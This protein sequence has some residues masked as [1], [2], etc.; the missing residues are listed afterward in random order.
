MILKYFLNS[1]IPRWMVLLIDICIS[2][3]SIVVAYLLRFN[4]RIPENYFNK[5]NFDSLYFVI[6]IVL[7]VRLISFLISKSYTGIIRYAGTKDAGRIF[8]VLLSGS[9]I[10]GLINLVFYSYYG[11]FL[12]PLSVIGIDFLAAMFMMTSLRL[13][14]K[15]AYLVYRLRKRDRQNAII[16]GINEMAISTNKTIGKSIELNLRIIGFIDPFHKLA[17]K[18]IDGIPAFRESDLEKVIAK[19]NVKVLILAERKIPKQVKDWLIELCLASNV[20]VLTLPNVNKWLRGEINTRQIRQFDI[21]DL[22]E[23][24]PIKLDVEEIEKYTLNKVILVTGAA[25]SIGKEIVKQ[26]LCFKP[27]KIVIFD[28]AETPLYDL[29]LELNEK[30]NF[31]NFEIVIGDITNQLRVQRVFEAFRPEVVFHAAAY[32]HVPMMENNPSESII[33]N[34][35][36]TRILADFSIRFGV[37][38]FVMISTDKAVKPTN[39]MGASKRIAEMYVQSLNE[40]KKT[41]FITTRFGNVLGSNGSVINRFRD[42]IKNGGPL[43]V[44]HPEITRYFMTIPEA[45]QLVLEAGAMGKGGEIFIFDMGKSVKI[46]NLAKKMIQLSGLVLNKDIEIKYTGLRP[47]EKL[48]EELL[49]DKENTIPTYHPQIT[50]GKVLSYPYSDIEKNVTELVKIGKSQDNFA[51][52]EK[53]KEIVPDYISQNSIYEEIDLSKHAEIGQ[54]IKSV[55]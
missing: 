55:V 54:S 14:V 33:T 53:M 47:G 44:T 38:K 41:Q 6:P 46:A 37:T 40:F 29:E 43:T 48:Y 20:N 30:Y 42:Q 27:N 25:G 22:L 26:L 35:L 10:F 3:I 24:D 12:L 9:I 8:V 52:V 4:F 23:R 17:G 21:N 28:Q 15:T 18:K 13:F 16:Y 49:N 19:N 51:I 36:G 39:V 34:V 32:K 1:H 7:S 11:R 50:I 5:E 31:N 45:C 2:L